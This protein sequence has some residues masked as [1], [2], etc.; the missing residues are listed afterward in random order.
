MYIWHCPTTE[1]L[2]KGVILFKTETPILQNGVIKCPQCKK[3]HSFRDIETANKNNIK[4]YFIELN[5]RQ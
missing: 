5:K 1:C 3:I 4:K 2:E